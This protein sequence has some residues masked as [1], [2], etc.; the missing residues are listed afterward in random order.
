MS[1]AQAPDLLAPFDYKQNIC[2]YIMPCFQAGM[3]VNGNR[4][5][6]V[7]VQEMPGLRLVQEAWT[8]FLRRGQL[9]STVRLPTEYTRCGFG[10]VQ[11][12]KQGNSR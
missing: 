4:I 5:S 8:G 9:P 6:Q 1:R 2:H 10:K 11:D 7:L 3:L 12:Q